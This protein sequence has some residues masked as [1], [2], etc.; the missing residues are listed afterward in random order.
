MSHWRHGHLVSQAVEKE[1][2]VTV[3]LVPAL[4][5]CV[6]G[7]FPFGLGFPRQLA[8]LSAA[9]AETVAPPVTRPV[10]VSHLPGLSS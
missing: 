5:R 4:G 7:F 3:V 1:R 6:R 9:T 2:E 10:P 8:E